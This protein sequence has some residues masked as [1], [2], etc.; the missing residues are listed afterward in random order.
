MSSQTKDA[1]RPGDIVGGRYRV[2]QEMGEDPLERLYEAQD[3]SRH[4]RVLLRVMRREAAGRPEARRRFDARVARSQEEEGLSVRLVELRADGELGPFAALACGADLPFPDVWAHVLGSPREARPPQPPE[5]P[6]T[7]PSLASSVPSPAPP[8]LPADASFRFPSSLDEV[9][10]ESPAQPHEPLAGAKK[11]PRFA[12]P[13]RP[14]KLETLEL[15][16]P[17]RGRPAATAAMAGTPGRAA[18]SRLH[19]ARLWAALLA[20][21]V[22]LSLAG[23][24]YLLAPWTDQEWTSDGEPRKGRPD[25]P[26]P[27]PGSAGRGVTL[28]PPRR[29]VRLLFRVSPAGARMLVRGQVAPGH[30]INVPESDRPLEIRFEADGHL[31]RSIRVVPDRDRTITVALER[32]P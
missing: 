16:V 25:D 32:K 10:L 4:E 17:H 8:P 19:G 24:V 11:P 21:A 23:G 22:L 1:L 26:G 13:R 29:E 30:T 27:R 15:D 20:M 31:P 9:E 28:S 18:R 12:E 5:A 6:V 2:I 7:V 3:V 14:R